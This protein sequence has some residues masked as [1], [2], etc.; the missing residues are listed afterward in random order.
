MLDSASDADAAEAAAG[1]TAGKDAPE[2]ATDGSDASSS[3]GARLSS[4][5]PPST[6]PTSSRGSIEE[7]LDAAAAAGPRG[8]RRFGWSH[9]EHRR[10]RVWSGAEAGHDRIGDAIT[11]ISDADRPFQ[12][13]SA[14]LCNTLDDTPLL[15][16]DALA[17]GDNFS[18]LQQVRALL[19]VCL[20]RAL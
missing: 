19:R 2:E 18:P 15:T 6:A 20:Q 9:D 7:R 11:A 8:G 17:S 10:G 1:A 12:P 14:A 5:E 13:Y 3:T 16:P 4:D